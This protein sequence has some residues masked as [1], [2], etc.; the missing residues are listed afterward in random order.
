MR[1]LLQI[2]LLLACWAGSPAHAAVDPAAVARLASE[3]SDEKL[4][5]IRQLVQGGDPAIARLL[6]ALSE[7]RLQTSGGRVLLVDG[8]RGH[9]EARG[10]PAPLASAGEGAGPADQGAARARARSREPEGP[11]SG[12]A[13]RRGE[14]PRRE[15]RPRRQEPARP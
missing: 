7:E 13:A 6:Q 15:R 2:L 1:R 8:A 9:G 14:G 10:R 12:R 3:D 11:R 5:A 4:A